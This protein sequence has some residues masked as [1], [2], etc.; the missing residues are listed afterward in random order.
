[1]CDLAS[2]TS[3]AIADCSACKEASFAA[4]LTRHRGCAEQIILPDWRAWLVA[5]LPD[6]EDAPHGT[7]FRSPGSVWNCHQ[8]GPWPAMHAIMMPRSMLVSQI[9][10]SSFARLIHANTIL[11]MFSSREETGSG[12]VLCK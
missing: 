8:I 6:I 1:M 5:S 9:P 11:R 2:K 10:M 3:V 7:L 12:S 4:A